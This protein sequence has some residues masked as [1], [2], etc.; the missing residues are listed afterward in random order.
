MKKIN[1][2]P[3]YH[4]TMTPILEVLKDGEPI[5][6]GLLKKVVRDKYYSHLSD[7]L[8]NEKTKS[9][10]PIVIS[11]IHFGIVTLLLSKM[12][13]ITNV[14]GKDMIKITSSG[15]KI[16]NSS[17][18]F[19]LE[20]LKTNESYIKYREN[21][22]AS[23]NQRKDNNIK[24]EEVEEVADVDPIQALERT[25]RDLEE[26]TQREILKTLLETDPIKFEEIILNLLHKMGYKDP[27]GTPKSHDGGIDGLIKQDVLGLDEIYIQVKRYKE[28][29]KITDTQMRDFIGAIS[30]KTSKGIFVTTSSFTSKAENKVNSVSH[31]ISLIDGN[32]LA[33]LMYKYNC[34]VRI[35]GTYEVKELDKS[36]FVE[37]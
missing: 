9:G 20:E 12:I 35:S 5:N 27:I 26:A 24:D 37:E 1:R 7:D 33:T 36:Y 29:T 3:R 11:R 14:D 16:M 34:G 6:R 13:E 32:K 2:L 19:G 17:A 18:Q 21:A 10:M 23:R 30:G 15:E 31:K 8:L 25:C 28:E 22:I 4:E